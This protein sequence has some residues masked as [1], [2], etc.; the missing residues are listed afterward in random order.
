MTT[1]VYVSFM[2]ANP[3]EGWDKSTNILAS[4]ISFHSGTRPLLEGLYY[5]SVLFFF[6]YPFI[7]KT[8]YPD[9]WEPAVLTVKRDGYSIKCSGPS[10]VAVTEKFSPSTTVCISYL[11]CF[12]MF[13]H[14]YHPSLPVQLLDVHARERERDRWIRER[15]RGF[16]LRSLEKCKG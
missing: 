11:L 5:W 9:I 8:G 16:S 6:L 4:H 13:H 7:V 3:F 14:Q 12:I 1:F 10:G 2:E 15:E